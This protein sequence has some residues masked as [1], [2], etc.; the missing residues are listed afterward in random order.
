[1]ILFVFKAFGPWMIQGLGNVNVHVL[2][3]S[4]FSIYGF[5]LHLRNVSMTIYHCL[6]SHV[7]EGKA[8]GS[9]H[10]QNKGPVMRQ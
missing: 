9:W 10:S 7:V 3:A 6:G 8:S 5:V 1:M 4:V 2:G